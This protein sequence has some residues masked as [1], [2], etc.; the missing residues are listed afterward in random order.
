MSG[1]PFLSAGYGALQAEPLD[2]IREGELLP[3]EAVGCGGPQGRLE[4]TSRGHDESGDG[5]PPVLEC[6]P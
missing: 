4:T 5:F 1:L 6:G 2:R 3:I